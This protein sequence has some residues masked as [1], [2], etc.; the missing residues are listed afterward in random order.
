MGASLKSE[1]I[2]REYLLGRVSDET[3]LARLEEL[4][5]SDEEFCSRVEL[6]E[7]DLIN[8]YVIGRLNAGDAESFR[9]TLAGNSERRFKVELTEGL[10]EKA[11]ARNWRPVEKKSSLLT[12]L[13]DF[14][15]QPQ[16]AGAL[17]ILL[18]AIV[19]FVVYFSRQPRR[20]DLAELRSLYRQARPT[21]SRISEFSYAPLSQL[22]GP[23]EAGE[24]RNLRRIENNLLDAT[25][26]SSNAQSHHALGV[27]HLTQQKYS[28]AI[29]ELETAVKFADQN[30]Q[31]H[32]DLGV[33]H[34]ELSKTVANEKKLQ[35]LEHSLDEFT[36]ATELDSNLLEALFNKSLALQEL[37]LS[38][39][40]KESWTFYL[41]KD[42]S[43]PWADEAR[44][45]LA[46][47]EGRQTSLSS[48]QVLSDF[49]TA[50]RNHDDERAYKI[51][52]ETK[53]TLGRGRVTIPLQLA[54][55]YLIARQQGNEAEI[56]ESLAALTYIGDFE[57]AQ[58]GDFFFFEL[59][60]FYASAGSEKI[61]ALLQAQDI[62]NAGHQLA[63]DTA[64]AISQF[65]KGRDL[66]ARLGD[67]CEAAI[68]ESWA[69]QFLPD[70][71]KVAES[72]SRVAS[73]LANAE[74]KR[75]LVL[76]PPAYYWLGMGDYRQG[77]FSESARNLKTA[78]QLAQATNNI[79]EIQHT[80]HALAV[81]YSELGELEPALLYAGKLL[82]TSELY[83][84]NPGQDWRN[85]GALGDLARKLRFFSTA[86]SIA[87]E[88]LIM[89]RKIFPPRTL[90]NDSLRSMIEAAT[91][92]KDFPAALKYASESM[93]A[94]M[95][96]G[97]TAENAR[98]IAEIYLL[99]ADVR[100]QSNGCHEALTDYDKALDLYRRFPEVSDTLYQI[101]KG[102]LFCF[103]QLNWQ[104]DFSNELKIVF[105]LSEAYRA[106]IREDDSRQAFF[107]SEQDVFDAATANLLAQRD[108]SRA[109]SLVEASKARSLLDFVESGKSITEVE[110][111]FGPVARP[112][113]LAEIQAR[114]PEQV[115][116]VQ[117]AVLSEKLAIWIVSKNRFDLLEKQVTSAE[118]ENKIEAYQLLITRR[119]PLAEIKRAAQDL[120][121]LLIPSDLA[122]DKQLCLVP[123]K[124]LNQLAFATLVSPAGAYLLQTHALF[125]SPSVSVLVLA[126]ENARRREKR[127]ENLLSIG[128]PDFDREENL[129]LP[130]LK[131]A[132][133]EARTITTGYRKSLELVGSQATKEKFLRNIGKVEIIHF[134]GHFLVNRRSPGNSK[135]LFANGELRTSELG[136]Y[137]LL[138]AKL[139]VLSACE[140]GFE[141]YNKSEGAIGIARTWLALGA[142]V[143]VASQWKVDS[144]ATKDLMI[145]FHRNRKQK[146]MS[147][148]ESLRQA[149]LE[150]LS[151]EETKAPSFWA[152]FSLF[153]GYA[154]Y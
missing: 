119:A 63:T 129:N 143:V 6:A 88:R 118:L 30:A 20:D 26:Q 123:D 133:I 141:L 82:K 66:F 151:R 112:L 29:K 98:K 110:K 57:Q 45:N 83:Y 111:S 69:V 3:T 78:L 127:D 100:R 50:Y 58:T 132:E 102:K 152:A 81:N 122:A 150:L 46:R 109:F 94:A 95:N 76:M 41:Q 74:N 134:A 115:Q 125:Y 73:I 72:R 68:A 24:Q 43:S 64:Q 22:R 11:R 139:V 31:I 135:L 56:K 59:A 144:E 70:I 47:L 86:L 8:D 44:K 52:N 131:D 105:K 103:Q 104:D 27:F 15:R 34:F 54:R 17:A 13:K 97:E 28:D 51:H 93:Q 140:T 85:K 120:H 16:Y 99:Q 60:I 14:L 42:P 35:E 84:Q 61:E 116:V 137:K 130:D 49:L 48:E 89:A 92:K 33:A 79:Y 121:E 91:A 113:S 148:A 80:Q 75:F 71:A 12:S 126:T 10:K 39:L 145:A 108:R 149:Q 5:F 106:T 107:A 77:H 101:H 23:L 36:K 1:E 142:P 37:G 114:L 55:R 38:Q 18:I 19:T 146:R 96:G 67:E 87:R 4:L 53:G 136:A 21:E 25:D 124:S 65:E 117:Y 9:T 154:S 40:A 2:V 7:E 147:S 62:L 128:N 32:N 153:G 138:A 90:L